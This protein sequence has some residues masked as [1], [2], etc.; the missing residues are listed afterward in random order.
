MSSIIVRYEN[1]RIY[2]DNDVFVDLINRD[3]CPKCKQIDE[4]SQLCYD[5]IINT[6]SFDSVLALGYYIG[7]WYKHTDAFTVPEVK[8][9]TQYLMEET[10]PIYRF[11]KLINDAKKKNTVK[12]INEKKNIINTL[13]K[14]F[15]WKL[16]RYDN[17]IIN[18][19]DFLVHVPKSDE[20]FNG[21]EPNI[22]N[23]GFYYAYYLS[24]ELNIP[25]LADLIIENEGYSWKKINRFNISHN[26]QRIQG[27]NV[28]IIDDVYT[29]SNTKEPIAHLLRNNGAI[30]V[31]IGVMGRTRR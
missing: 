21:S 8:E 9:W 29:N 5:C 6:Y 2:L 10:N 25:F 14:G 19:I 18:T 27:K 26:P 1:G 24:E 12:T 3:Y 23:H 30:K 22:F 16:R 15:A 20:D 13:C 31:Y 7:R 11:C 4:N 28:I 17:L